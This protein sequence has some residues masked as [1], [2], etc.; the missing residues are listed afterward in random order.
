MLLRSAPRRLHLLRPHHLRLLSAAALASAAP[1]PAPVPPQAPTEWAEAPLAA[2][3]PATADASLYHVS[4]DLSAHGDL[5]ASHAAAGQFLPFRLPAAPYPIFLA[6][7]SP[8]PSPG[9]SAAAFDFLV[10]RLP[11][12]PSARLCDL[13]PGDLVQ[14]GASVVGRGFEV[15]RIAD[16][17]DVLVFAT[18]SGISP[19]RSLIESGFVE[20]NKTGVSLFYGVRNLQRMAYQERFD[21]WEAKGVKIVPVLS[22]PDGQWT[23][24]R[25]YVQNV[26]S[27]MK[28]ILNPSSVGAILCGHK[29]MTEEITRILVADG[30]SKDRILTN[31]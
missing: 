23:G 7:A 24:E 28:D 12:T 25:G 16:A 9:S 26:F 13:R 8:P 17:R 1:T 15:A 29:Q 19:I 2:V 18:G 31:F 5:L 22:R 6:I 21:D 10:K 3:R 11:G 27:R 20:N 30:L 14:V 4:L